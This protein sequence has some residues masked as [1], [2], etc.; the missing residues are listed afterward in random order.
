MIHINL[1]ASST[2]PVVGALV[3]LPFGLLQTPSLGLS[4]LRAA[5]KDRAHMDVEVVYANLEFARQIGED[6]YGYISETVSDSLLIGDAVFAKAL[7]GRSIDFEELLTT[8]YNKQ[9]AR[10]VARLLQPL[11]DEAVTF[12]KA[13]A[14]KLADN[15]YSIIGSTAMF[16]LAPS[17]ALAGE[18]K[19]IQPDSKY[20]LGGPICEGDPG[21]Q[22]HRSYPSIDFVCRGEGETLFPSLLTK[23]I[24]GDSS[25]SDVPG[26]VY[27]G[28]AGESVAVG[29]HPAQENMDDL[30]VPTYFDWFEQFQQ[31]DLRS[32]ISSIPFEASRGCWWGSKSHCTFC[33]LNG[34]TLHFR[35]KSPNRAIQELI[36]L[37]VYGVKNIFAVDNILDHSY[38]KSVL[39]RLAELDHGLSIFYE[40]KSNV[41]REQVRSLSAA[42]I[43][44]VQPGI[45]S[46]NTNVLK[47]MRKG[48]SAL[49]NI[50]LL[51]WCQEFGVAVGWNLL[52][53][54]PKESASDY[55]EMMD[56]VP[57]IHHLQ[58]PLYG[59]S[60]VR[61]DRF[62]PLWEQQ[63]I[64]GVRS[65]KPASAYQQVYD[66]V[67]EEDLVKLATFFDAE[68]VSRESQQEYWPVVSEGVVEWKELSRHSVLVHYERGDGQTV[69]L[70]TRKVSISDRHV[71]SG[72]AA[73]VYRDIDAARTAE[74][75]A[76]STGLPLEIIRHTLD[77]LVE[78]RLVLALDNR[79]LALS[80]EVPEHARP[81][82]GSVSLSDREKEALL[83]S[84]C[85]VR[86][87]QMVASWSANSST[88]VDFVMP[89]NSNERIA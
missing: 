35:S 82:L 47:L 89:V 18:I 52:V 55:V 84:I 85:S 22:I 26:V 27:R 87:K 42:G 66:S 81:I 72:S 17:L 31:S 41:S 38:Y 45:E 30:P 58:A 43:R 5:A 69:V 16:Q 1:Q 60:P 2:L 19:R 48:V 14:R 74:A 70:D 34:A 32:G 73:T 59:P 49:Q 21:L 6:L 25:F 78:R 50:Q 29:E 24:N 28:L 77:D 56:M 68:T 63:H 62:S 10:E 46:L 80:Y 11:Q 61:I 57:Y 71:L 23:L 79:Y 76:E 65:V 67:P 3:Q 7:S 36:G 39:P 75:V 37:K 12:T 53:G 54:F 33:G 13:L 8:K 86:M 15:R 44:A 51:K 83:I 20:L 88:S 64:L 4:L 9:H 40:I